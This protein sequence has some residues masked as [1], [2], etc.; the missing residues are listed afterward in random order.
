MQERAEAILDEM[1]ASQL[2]DEGE[3]QAKTDGTSHSNHS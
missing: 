1:K 3:S 2:P